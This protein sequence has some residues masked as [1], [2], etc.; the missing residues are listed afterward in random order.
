MR[1]HNLK[2]H[3]ITVTSMATLSILCRPLREEE[4]VMAGLLG[5]TK[6]P[7]LEVVDFGPPKGREV[8]AKEPIK[9]GQYVC[10]YR[11]Y[12][13]YP[14]G[15]EEAQ[16]LAREY[17]RNNEGSF[18]LQTAYA[19]P[20][21][22]HR[23]CFD[24]TRRFK[25]V[26]R[27][28]NHA[29]SGYNLKPSKPM[30]VRNKWRVG[31]VAVR[32]I[33]MDAELT[34]DYGVRKEGWMRVRGGSAGAREEDNV[35][36]LPQ[37]DVQILSSKEEDDM[38]TVSKTK[39][40]TF[41]CPVLDCTSGLV[42]KMT[43]KKHKMKVVMA[44]KLAKKKRRAPAEAVRLKVPNPQTR[45]SKMKNLALTYSTACDTPPTLQ[46]GDASTPTLASGKPAQFPTATPTTGTPTQAVTTTP[47][48]RKA[49]QTST[50]TPPSWKPAHSVPH[51][52]PSTSGL[53]GNF[54]MGGQFLDA[55][56]AHLKTRAGGKRG[57]HATTQ[58]VRY[59][60][61]YLHF[62]NSSAVEETAL[63][64]PSPVLEYLGAIHASG[65][66]SCG[67]LH[68]I[69]AHK[70]AVNFMRMTV[71]TIASVESTPFVCFFWLKDG[72]RW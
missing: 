50:A 42:P 67:I 23:L 16:S 24:A 53:N 33:P 38:Q 2:T 3:C 5:H 28:I 64:D 59:V 1:A 69:L 45:S 20:G 58:I 71:S 4:V 37:E 47:T 54:H 72:R 32:G 55:F 66:G 12:R 10:E 49:A 18:V 34:Y 63:L 39:L 9:K 26:G 48:S 46:T 27:L 40:P 68:L 44:A 31:M 13:V 17:E 41:R 62:L 7:R 70:A 29:A 14:V 21:V 19:V 6:A 43:Q 25:D 56:S 51:C 52:T 8:V 35:Q 61:K 36:I 60:G 22:G 57:D 11:T 30:Y 15:S 65:I